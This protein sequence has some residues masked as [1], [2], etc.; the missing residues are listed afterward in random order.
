MYERVTTL[1]SILNL[2]NRNH[3]NSCGKKLA[4]NSP[5]FTIIK[6]THIVFSSIDGGVAPRAL[7]LNRKAN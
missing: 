7:A 2:T 4:N 1:C 5:F 6:P 3:L